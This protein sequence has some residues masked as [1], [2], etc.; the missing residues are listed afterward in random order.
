MLSFKGSS[1]LYY[2]Q[3]TVCHTGTN[4]FFNQLLL[5]SGQ[6][7]CGDKIIILLSIS[8][9]VFL[10]G[11]G[12]VMLW[13]EVR[14]RYSAPPL[15][16]R[17]DWQNRVILATVRTCWLQYF[18]FVVSAYLWQQKW[19]FQAKTLAFPYP[20]QDVFFLCLNLTRPYA[21]PCHNIKHRT[22]M[23]RNIKF[24][25][26]TRSLRFCIA[27]FN[28]LAK[29][30][31]ALSRLPKMTITL[32]QCHIKRHFI[33]AKDNSKQKNDWFRTKLSKKTLLCA[34]SP[35]HAWVSVCIIALLCACRS[36]K[37]DVC[38][39]DQLSSSLLFWSATSNFL[40]H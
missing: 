18:F 6:N 12:V 28:L 1:C 13:T 25:E 27:S 21:E 7:V 31:W 4:R 22:F 36:L 5:H 33:H 8:R 23:Q 20:H 16:S 15:A 40:R 39:G 35:L 2:P 37:Y 32:T 14:D 30:S 11:G 9:L 26:T 19:A 34:C 38:D 3:D 29:G 24:A 17:C 10:S